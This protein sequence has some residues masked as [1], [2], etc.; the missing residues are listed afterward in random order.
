MK[1][2][3]WKCYFSINDGERCKKVNNIYSQ[4]KDSKIKPFFVLIKFV[5]FTQKLFRTN[6]VYTREQLLKLSSTILFEKEF[7]KV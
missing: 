2:V 1:T 4:R 5:I 7:I 6:K 3:L